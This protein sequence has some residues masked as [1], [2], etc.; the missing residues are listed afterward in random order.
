MQ[1]FFTQYETTWFDYV[2]ADLRKYVVIFKMYFKFLISQTF[3]ALIS[4]WRW[5]VLFGEKLIICGSVKDHSNAYS[6]KDHGSAFLKQRDPLENLQI[7]F[8]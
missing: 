8:V 7:A 6:L 2:H 1:A 3:E 4:K 5:Q